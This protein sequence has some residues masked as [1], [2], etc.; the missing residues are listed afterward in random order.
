MRSTEVKVTTAIRPPWYERMVAS[1]PTIS[2]ATQGA[3]RL[4]STLPIH[5]LITPGQARSRPHAPP[6]PLAPCGPDDPGELQRNGEARVQDGDNRADRHDL[7]ESVAE[8]ALRG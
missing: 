2:V 7:V 8:R 4:G 6:A 3:P 1:A 5:S